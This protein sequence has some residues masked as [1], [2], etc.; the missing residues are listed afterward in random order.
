MAQATTAV[1]NVATAS[2][3]V[4]QAHEQTSKN[5]AGGR[6][7]GDLK[8]PASFRSEFSH[9][10]KCSPRCFRAGLG[11][12]CRRGASA[13]D[14]LQTL[15]ANLFTT[16]SFGDRV[17]R[18][19]PPWWPGDSRAVYLQALGRVS[20]MRSADKSV[21]AFSAG[22]ELRPPMRFRQG[23]RHR[24][25]SETERVRVNN[26]LRAASSMGG[27]ALLTLISY[28][29]AARRVASAHPRRPP[30]SIALA[31]EKRSAYRRRRGLRRRPLLAADAPA[32][33]KVVM[34][35]PWV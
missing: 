23:R 20:S 17:R 22:K 8:C 18:R 9:T 6:A 26:R 12:V 28:N 15:V 13:A 32:Q 34:P 24:Q 33:Q 25:R 5:K 35:S 11:G 31:A 21:D 10:F 14:L 29:A 3:A 30:R 4:R 1:T 19:S 16:G 7:R 27:W 2:A